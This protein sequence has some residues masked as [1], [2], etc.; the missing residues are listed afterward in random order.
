TLWLFREKLAS[1][2]LI[3]KLLERFDQ[4]LEAKGYIARGG[5]MID[6]TIVSVPKQRNTRDEND[7][8][9]AASTRGLH[10]STCCVVT[11]AASAC[12]GANAASSR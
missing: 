9:K 3:E 2:G 10:S 5:Q 4:H 7:A 8:I 12:S 1:A 6:A 11:F